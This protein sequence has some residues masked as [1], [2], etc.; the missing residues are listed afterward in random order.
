MWFRLDSRVLVVMYGLSLFIFVLTPFL[1]YSQKPTF[2]IPIRS[3]ERPHVVKHVLSCRHGIMH[4]ANLQILSSASE[5]L[6]KSRCKKTEFFGGNVVSII[7]GNVKQI[8]FVF[9][10]NKNS[11]KVI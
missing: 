9:G 1:P 11:C 8:P 6:T 4:Y 2:L 5:I 7:R 10:E 3:G